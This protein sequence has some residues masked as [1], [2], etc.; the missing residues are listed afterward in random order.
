MGATG[1]PGEIVKLPS[2]G[3]LK[4]SLVVA[5]GLDKA[6]PADHESIRRAR[7]SSEPGA[8]RLHIGDLRSAGQHGRAGQRRCRR[9]DAGQLRVHQVQDFRADQR[10]P[11]ARGRDHHRP[12]TGQG[13][14][15]R[16]EAAQVVARAVNLTRDWINTPP[17]TS[18]RLSSP[19]QPWRPPR[20][21]RSAV[22]VLDEKALEREGYGGLIGVGQGSANPPRLVKLT[23]R[24]RRAQDAIWRSSAK[25]S[26][27][28]PAAC[29]SSRQRHG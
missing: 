22:R 4:P 28:T 21:R 18:F 12:G 2:A 6:E 7:G 15:V 13:G 24:P 26:R 14:P 16:N 25:G 8:G 5:V 1:K 10:P 20:P 9:G 19:T 11:V 29:R 23:Y 27:S 17:A 3:K